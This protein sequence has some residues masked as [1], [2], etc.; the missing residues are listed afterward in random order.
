MKLDVNFLEVLKTHKQV[1]PFDYDLVV[2]WA[3]NMLLNN[4][5]YESLIKIASMSKP[6]FE[7]EIVD[8]V[9]E[10]LNDFK[11]EELVAVDTFKRKANYHVKMILQS[12]EIRKHLESLYKIYL[13][14]DN[15]DYKVFFNLHH[16]WKDLESDF[17]KQEMNGIQMYYKGATLENIKELIILESKKWLE[18]CDLYSC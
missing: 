1:E 12:N 8:Y 6:I 15:P 5:N 7:E 16:A 11:I 18:S 2:D 14:S 10:V 4:Y 17:I 13:E 9:T 3:V